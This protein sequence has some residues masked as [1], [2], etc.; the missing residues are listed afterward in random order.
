MA[1]IVEKIKKIINIEKYGFLQAP[2][3]SLALCLFFL[4]LGLPHY[5]S[6]DDY[7]LNMIS[8][9]NFGEQNCSYL[10]FSNICYGSIINWLNNTIDFVNWHGVVPIFI[11]IICF[12]VMSLVFVKMTDIYRGCILSFLFIVLFCNEVIINF[13]FTHLAGFFSAVGLFIVCICA[14]K[15]LKTNKRNNFMLY[16]F[17]VIMSLLGFWIRYESFLSVVLILVAWAFIALFDYLF[18]R[19][20]Y[21]IFRNLPIK[22]TAIKFGKRSWGIFLLIIL[23]TISAITDYNV[24]YHDEGWHYWKDYNYYRSSLLDYGIPDYHTYESDYKSIGVE[25]IDYLTLDRWNYADQNVFSIEKLKKMNDLR[26]RV[27]KDNNSVKGYI[28]KFIK[29]ILSDMTSY[30]SIIALLVFISLSILCNKKGWRILFPAMA[31]FLELFYL[32]VRGRLIFRAYFGILVII[33][34][35]ALITYFQGKSFLEKTDSRQKKAIVSVLLIILMIF[36]Y[37]IH[38]AKISTWVSINWQNDVFS[39]RKALADDKDCLFTL[40]INDSIFPQ[41]HKALELM[42]KYYHNIYFLGGWTCPSPLEQYLLKEYGV[43]EEGVIQGLFDNYANLYY[44]E[45]YNVDNRDLMLQYIHKHYDKNVKYEK[46]NQF[47]GVN[48]FRFYIDE[49]PEELNILNDPEISYNC[50]IEK[51]GKKVIITGF[52]KSKD[53]D[54][55]KQNVWIRIDSKQKN[56]EKNSFIRC[57]KIVLEEKNKIKYGNHDA[58]TGFEVEFSTNLLNDASHVELIICDGKG[59]NVST[60]ISGKIIGKK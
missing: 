41:S 24:Y 18:I 3:I 38:N 12:L 8:I 6:N 60:D 55:Y 42:P 20:K 25:E 9:G 50:S 29:L 45:G 49:K 48:I 35:I 32:V 26:L 5:V 57:S 23:I 53:I 33:S 1:D 31:A 52:C 58:A 11:G 17:G 21:K 15:P 4:K 27:N 22:E 19:G 46:V 30:Y 40:E 43:E 13:Q 2:I 16:S 54:P 51:K 14:F 10:P 37:Q 7:A 59:K 44:V 28:K 34:L 56:K 47:Q 39:Y 36:G